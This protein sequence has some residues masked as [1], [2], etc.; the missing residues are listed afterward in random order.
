MKTVQQKTAETFDA[1]QERYSDAV[2]RSI[3]FTGCDVDFFTKVKAQYIFDLAS[4]HFGETRKLNVLDVG[5]GVGNYHSLLSGTFKSLDGVDVSAASIE[6]A[7]AKHP[8]VSYKTYDGRLLPYEDGALDMVFT[9]CVMHHVPPEN[10]PQFASEMHRVLRP[11][12]LALVFEHNPLNPLTMKAVN[13]CP[14][15]AD[16]VLLRR[17][18]TIG[19]MKGAGFEKVTARFIISVPP[20]NGFLFAIDRM[21]SRLPLGAQYYVSAVRD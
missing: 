17:G 2:N 11:G 4:R 8:D 10:W 3:A 6:T 5:C 9:I 15:D 18:E 19:L 1:Y 16:A 20:A 7:S 12:G 13:S 14:F 21:L